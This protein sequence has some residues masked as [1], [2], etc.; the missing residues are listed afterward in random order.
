MDL[1]YE[2]IAAHISDYIENE[3]FFDTIE[4]KDI[5][6]IMKHSHLTVD[7]FNTLLKQSSSTISS[8]KLYT[9]TRKAYVTIQNNEDILSI[10]KSVK[11]CMKFN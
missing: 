7:Q 2:Y 4:I 9:C 8:R 1:N 10:L 5:E 3:N 6:K 11:K